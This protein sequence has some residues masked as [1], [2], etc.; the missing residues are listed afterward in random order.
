MYRIYDV[1]CRTKYLV[2]LFI[3]ILTLSVGLTGCKKESSP[4]VEQAKPSAVNGNQD[5]TQ[6]PSEP[7]VENLGTVKQGYV[8]VSFSQ[9]PLYAALAKGFF[10]KHGLKV[11]SMYIEG[12]TAVLAALVSGEIQVAATGGQFTMRSMAQGMELKIVAR[13]RRTA[14]F[15]VLGAKGVETMQDL[16]GQPLAIS[17]VGDSTWATFIFALEKS[18]MSEKDVTFMPLGGKGKR[19]AALLSGSVKATSIDPPYDRLGAKEG[20]KIIFDAPSYDDY[21][22]MDSTTIFTQKYLSTE[23]GKKQTE[24]YL[25]GLIE[26]AYF[27]MDPKNKEESLKILAK[28]MEMSLDKDK[29]ELE[30]TLDYYQQTD[31]WKRRPYVEIEDV[32]VEIERLAKDT[33]EV[34]KFGP[35]DYVDYSFL[36]KIEDSGYFSEMEKIYQK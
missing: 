17:R 8:A 30:A 13:S 1:T 24:A 12:E 15:F 4:P 31:M 5:K 14:P 33:P 9:G 7:K 26:G 10:E 34:K 28:F 35:E 2:G 36:K 23:Q 20:M 19:F 27:L 21:T 3:L 32:K 22:V 11:E 29:D 16:K 18:G 6:A 25:K